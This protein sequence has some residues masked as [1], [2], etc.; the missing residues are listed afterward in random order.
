MSYRH[1]ILVVLLASTLVGWGGGESL[2]SVHAAESAHA[3][4]HGEEHAGNPN[5]LAIDPDLAIFTGL[6]FLLLFFLLA[7]FAWPAISAALLERE[8]AIRNDIAEAA[9]KHEEAKQML[10][11]Y[12]AKLA[13]AANEVRGLLD[14]ARRGRRGARECPARV[15]VGQHGADHQHAG[16][17]LLAVARRDTNE[18]HAG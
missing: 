16:G 15:D 13:S 1:I 10:L 8:Q 3:D 17:R 4:A 5:P 11:E 7:K 18:R 6:V 12:E 9:M 2:C 14:E